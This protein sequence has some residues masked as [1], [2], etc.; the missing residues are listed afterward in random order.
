L[1][2]YV[3]N[4]LAVETCPWIHIEAAN[5]RIYVIGFNKLSQIVEDLVY[6]NFNK[7]II[8]DFFSDYDATQ[9]F[10]L[11]TLK[12]TVFPNTFNRSFDTLK[13]FK[14]GQIGSPVSN[15]LFFLSESL[16][17]TFNPA[18]NVSHLNNTR[19]LQFWKI[20]S[21]HPGKI[22]LPE[23][24]IFDKANTNPDETS[25]YNQ[26]VVLQVIAE[27]RAT[28]LAN[29]LIMLHGN[30]TYGYVSNLPLN[31]VSNSY[32]TIVDYLPN[33][34]I[35]T[36]A[37]EVYNDA[38]SFAI[39]TANISHI[40][41]NTMI[42]IESDSGYVVTT[43]LYVANSSKTTKAS[44]VDVTGGEIMK[45]FAGWDNYLHVANI[46]ITA[47]GAE[48]PDGRYTIPGS[49]TY[50]CPT[51]YKV[52]E[53]E[54]WGGGG[55]GG[56]STDTEPTKFNGSNGVNSSFANL[57]FAG[58][59]IG[60]NGATA[61][62]SVNNALGGNASGGNV[63]I[64][65]YSGIIKSIGG[66]A[67]GP[68]GGEGGPTDREGSEPGG[69][70]GGHSNDFGIEIGIITG[71]GGGSGAYSRVRWLGGAPGA[72]T[73]NITIIVGARGQGNGGGQ[74]GGNGAVIVKVT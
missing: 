4:D 9:F 69:G 73:G 26:S 18:E 6:E 63:N 34:T 35:T 55:G 47:I 44:P 53:I 57:V 67:P 50:R 10:E 58:G 30:P 52:L 54:L 60:G 48:V 7:G 31:A 49:Y 11:S 2:N 22:S 15:A 71:G 3:I 38:S 43:N 8:Q 16:V 23:K 5:N 19:T 70:G 14:G 24:F 61:A 72:P 27:L 17:Y 59:G 13:F 20:N 28:A 29:C 36:D 46:S 32:Q 74:P 68:G 12:S 65:G 21:A 1:P 25:Q 45:I 56:G 39:L 51:N 37:T 64:N 62:G 40:N 42:N 41:A 66:T 33:I